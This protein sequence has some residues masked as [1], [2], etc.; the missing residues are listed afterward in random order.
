MHADGGTDR[1]QTDRPVRPDSSFPAESEAST[2]GRAQD[3]E[4]M[5]RL[6]RTRPQRRSARRSPTPGGGRS[7]PALRR[8][9]S[10]ESATGPGPPRGGSAEPSSDSKL[11]VEAA[12]LP[13]ELGARA[14]L[15]A[16]DAIVRGLRQ[17]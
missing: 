4:I 5:S 10:A 9:R 17:R 12:K 15:R 13:I 11:L 6:P 8:E 2:S 7:G 3:A 16:L 14:T 1:P